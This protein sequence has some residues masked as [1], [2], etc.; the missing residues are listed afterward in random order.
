MAQDSR[1][2]QFG[3]RPRPAAEAHQPAEPK[4]AEPP[5]EKKKKKKADPGLVAAGAGTE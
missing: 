5:C 1:T 3:P 2:T 4:P